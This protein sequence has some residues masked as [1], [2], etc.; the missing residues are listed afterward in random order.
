[1]D[2]LYTFEYCRG[3]VQVV[4]MN[5]VGSDEGSRSTVFAAIVASYRNDDG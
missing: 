4:G 1:M 2:G 5:S 3:A